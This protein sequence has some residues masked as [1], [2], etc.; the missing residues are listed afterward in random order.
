[1]SSP[2]RPNLARAP[3]KAPRNRRI[4]RA[5]SAASQN[6]I[7]VRIAFATGRSRPRVWR[8]AAPALLG[9]ELVP[10]AHAPRPV[11]L[12]TLQPLQGA[13]ESPIR[14]VGARAINPIYGRPGCTTRHRLT[15]CTMPAT[16]LAC[17]GMVRAAGGKNFIAMPGTESHGPDGVAGLAK[18][19]FK[20]ARL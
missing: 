17:R 16:T 13:P 11:R 15:L 20:G 3:I 12:H 14:I 9:A 4:P 2:Y 1:M 18:D 7:R 8:R 5:K 6:K 19:R 10:G